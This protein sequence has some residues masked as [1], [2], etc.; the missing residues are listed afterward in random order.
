M[1][2]T[3]DKLQ[4]IGLVGNSGKALCGQVISKAARLIRKAGREIFVDSETAKLAHLRGQI[5]PDAASVA[6]AVDLLLVFGGDGTML[7]VAREIAGSQTPILGINIGGLGF[8]TAVPSADLARALQQVWKGHFKFEPRVLLEA[9][10]RCG[11]KTIRESALND[12][13]I[14]RGIASRLIE[15]HVSVD[16]EPLTRY[17]CDG[18]IVSS[19]TGSTAYS[20]AAGGS[21]VFPTAEVLQITPICPHTLSNRSLILPLNS[22]ICIKVVNPTPVTILSADGQVVTELSTGDELTF[23]RSRRTVRLMH[24]EDSSFFETLRVKLHWRGANL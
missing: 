22:K 1:K 16:G 4:R 19:P 6:E 7:R 5:L 14:S 21:V 9:T 18:L 2:K 10:A 3:T 15:L 11:G 23:Q 8:L 24:L 20:L 17:R 12:L 13:V